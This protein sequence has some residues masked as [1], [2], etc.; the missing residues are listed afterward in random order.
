MLLHVVSKTWQNDCNV[1]NIHNLKRKEKTIKQNYFQD[2]IVLQQ[3]LFYASPTFLLFWDL[4]KEKANI[5]MDIS[6]ARGSEL[7]QGTG[8][9]TE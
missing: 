9:D 1:R 2:C 8:G 5:H 3:S 7:W 4:I 6:G